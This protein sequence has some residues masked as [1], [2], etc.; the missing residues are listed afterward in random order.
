MEERHHLSVPSTQPVKR[1]PLYLALSL[2]W[3]PFLCADLKLPA[4]FGDH[5]VLQQKQS[6][7]VWG[8]DRPGTAIT[9]AFAGK[10]HSATARADGKWSVILDPLPAN[11][12]PQTL[13]FTGTTK[14]E[15]QDVLIGEVW[16]CSGQSNMQLRLNQDWNGDIE[17]A[18][19][20]HPN[21]RLIRVPPKGTQELQDD[22][23]GGWMAATP[24]TVASFS[25]LG[26]LYGRYL[27]EILDVPVGLIGNYWAGS[28]AEAWVRRSS[29]EADPRFASLMAGTRERETKALLP[30]TTATHEHALKKWEEDTARAKMAGQ[31][32]PRRPE[33]PEAWLAGFSRAGNIFAGV[34]HPTLGYGIK[35]VIW[36]QGEGNA[37]RAREYD[38]LFPFLIEQWRKEWGQGDF[39]FYWVQLPDWADERA[40]P[41]ESSQARLREAQ[42]KSMRLP[43]TGQ[44]VTIDLGEGKDRHPRNKHDIAARLVRWALVKDYGM[45]LPYRSPEFKSLSVTGSKALVTFDCFGSSLRPFDVDEAR[46]FAVCGEDRV[47]H[48]AKGKL[49]GRDRVELTCDAVPA[50][51]AVRFA[52]ADNP[53]CNL[54]SNDGLPVTPFRT[55]DFTS[56][57]RNRSAEPA[58]IIP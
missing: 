11:A 20:K 44:A 46:G 57:P 3:A 54:F 42:T 26:F 5:M 21:L 52:W 16:M 27:H 23:N 13:R 9:V 34:V 53:V 43:N 56:V 31:R 39:P 29:L 25:A 51:V 55:D 28:S 6:N 45:S 14:H 50:P 48:W 30:A 40:E 37:N 35:G 10:T 18:A 33:S 19:S 58:K 7:P 12:T 41:G 22:F 15:I 17:A 4:I 2:M 1:F 32:P 24:E 49:I 8:W 36:Y 47:W 38:D